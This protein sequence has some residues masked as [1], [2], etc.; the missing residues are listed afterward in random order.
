MKLAVVGAGAAGTA[1][2]WY[3]RRQNAEVVVF[4]DRA[5][6]TALS[7]GALDLDEW[8]GPTQSRKLS[9][10][11]VAFAAAF[12]A[13]HVGADPC[14]VA[15]SA[16]LI[17]PARG[18]DTALLD[19]AR[20]GGRSIAIADIEREDWD[21]PLL[22]HAL[23]DSEWAK[24]T[25]TRFTVVKVRGLADPAER[26]FGVYD[27]A[28]L[29]DDA[30][31]LEQLGEQLR[32]VA[33]AYGGWLL[34]PWLGTRPGAADRLRHKLGI[35]VGEISVSLDGPSGA[36]FENARDSLFADLGVEVQ[37]AKVAAVREQG[38]GWELSVAGEQP[39]FDKVVLALGGVAAGG[40]ELDDAGH[41]GGASF[42]LSVDAPVD[43]ELDSMR[44]LGA[45]SLHGVSFEAQ[46]REVLERVGVAV[47]GTAVPSHAG[48]FAAGDVVA[49]RPRTVLEAV[50]SGIEAARAAL[51]RR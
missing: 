49:G 8:D 39:R 43:L 34:G 51:G 5:G 12:E 27:F 7:S 36:R 48:L 13:W 15:T 47:E 38:G 33:G 6:A 1:A 3:G 30:E 9:A 44:L 18:I 28:A 19:L 17:R 2:A 41:P 50:S 31:R 29:H 21:A 16:G 14:R 23:G 26:S 42:H 32:G 24:Q 35:P 37:R 22:A 40:I 46:G 20:V 45:A 10:E 11:A 25:H 4:H